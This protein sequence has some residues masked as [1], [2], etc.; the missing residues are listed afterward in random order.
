MQSNP[1]RL[2]PKRPRS[3]SGSPPSPLPSASV[4]PLSSLSLPA[5]APVTALPSI[6]TLHP[7]LPPAGHHY[8]LP[9]AD[10]TG[11]G[12]SGYI[13]SFQ[14]SSRLLDRSLL[15]SPSAP[16]SSSAAASGSSTD[17]LRLH[18]RQRATS[19]GPDSDG[20]QNDLLEQTEPPKKKRRRQALSCTGMFSS[21][22]YLSIAPSTISPH[23][24][25]I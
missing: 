6:R 21:N 20:D 15:S 25:I 5:S 10:L 19:I 7:H 18:Q 17:R 22:S 4:P 13:P 2:S 24:S 1:R 14:S 8:L 23:F 16:V 3:S 12:Q 9:E 11:L